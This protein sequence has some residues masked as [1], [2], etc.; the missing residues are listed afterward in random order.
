MTC[1]PTSYTRYFAFLLPLLL[2]ACGGG[3]SD[4]PPPTPPV[5]STPPTV[6]AVTVPAGSSVNRVVSLSATAS[7]AGGISEVRF[8][9]DG[10]QVGSDTTA[11]YTFDWDTSALADGQYAL[12]A[13][14][15]DTAGNTAQSSAT[16]CAS[17]SLVACQ[18]E[19]CDF[20]THVSQGR[21]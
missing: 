8:L 16:G 18:G 17:T 19:R 13:E 4:A 15:V 10:A 3:G 21:H 12:T 1:M 6:S 11:P 7:D 14:A 9:V 20:A 5:D 2:T